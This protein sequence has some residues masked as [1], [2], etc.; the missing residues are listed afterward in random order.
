[1]ADMENGLFAGNEKYNPNNTALTS[2]FVTA[3]VKG[4]TDGFA[5]K[6]GDATQGALK[7]M[8]D[9]PRPAGYQVRG[10]RARVAMR[11]AA[12]ITN[13][14]SSPRTYMCLRSPC[15]SRGPS[16]SAL[17]EIIATVRLAPSGRAASRRA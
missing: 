13:I 12:P 17:V 14:H 3:M 10:G 6:G 8:Y 4:G 5:L 9:G 2:E 1:M 7:V 11:Y 16:S 15:G